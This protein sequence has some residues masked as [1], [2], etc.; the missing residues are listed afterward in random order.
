VNVVWTDNALRQLTQIY[1]YIAHDSAR[2]ALAMIDRI[3][4]RSQQCGQ[5]PLMAGKVPEYDCDDVR[6]VLEHPYRIIYRVLTERVDILAVIHG[7]RKLPDQL[8]E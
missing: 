7:A 5:F 1:D 2:Y 6:E 4:H 3:T 8:V